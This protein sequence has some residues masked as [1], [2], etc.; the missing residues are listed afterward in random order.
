MNRSSSSKK[1]KGR[2]GLALFPKLALSFL[3]FALA[4]SVAFAA[5]LLLAGLYATGNN[6][7]GM[8]PE[9]LVDE[10][11]DMIDLDSIYRLDGWVEK[12]DKDYRVLQVFGEKLTPDTSYDTSSLLALTS[13]LASNGTPYNAYVYPY[14]E[15]GGSGYYLLIYDRNHVSHSAQLNVSG[16][17]TTWSR[18]FLLIFGVLFLLISLVMSYY[19]VRQIKR[20]ME[21]LREGMQKVETGEA[22]VQL[23]F[24]ASPDLIE[25]RDS[26]NK[27]IRELDMQKKEKADME[28][29]KQRLLLELSHD[30]RTPVATI[31]S[32][33]SALSEDLVPEDQLKN[34]YHVIADKADRVTA[35]ATD[36]FAMLR[37]EDAQSPIH[38][39]E[40]ELNE[41]LRRF[42]ASYYSEIEASELHFELI[43]PDTSITLEA[44][45]ALLTRALG[46]LLSN[47]M[48]YNRSGQQIL[49]LA[50]ADKEKVSIR[51]IDDGEAIAEEE[52]PFLFDPFTRVDKVRQSSEGSGLG[53]AIASA[54]AQK[55]GGVLSYHYENGFN[56]FLM[57]LPV[58]NSKAI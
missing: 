9:S 46:N 2:K 42:C 48:K 17:Q 54:V 36:L 57:E 28:E 8:M 56:Q 12:L 10:K 31:K 7:T 1:N 29:K 27:M 3:I 40:M 21:A 35:L 24:K 53:L 50:D 16:T 49:L 38:S 34:Y 11:G 22:E 19:L 44:D 20:P 39:E 58:I 13:P 52:Q 14:E 41:F 51:V 6:L 43:L 45:P 23:D 4:I 30:L 32:F 15:E 25:L 55:H 5:S 47:A 33:A 26:F 37:M 18:M